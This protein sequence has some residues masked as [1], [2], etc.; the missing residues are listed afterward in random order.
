MSEKD[1]VQITQEYYDSEEA[2]NFYYHIWGGEDIHIGIYA[3]FE[4]PVKTAS[5]NT[6]AAMV[7]VLPGIN[8][9]TKI[10][11]IGSG[12]GGAA[13]YLASEYGC[14]VDCL[15]LSATENK[16]NEERNQKV[17]LDHLVSVTTGNFEDLPFEEGM[18]DIVWSQD[19]IL[20]SDKKA[21]VFEEVNR[22]LKPGGLFILT[23]P[24]QSDNCPDGVL[25]PILD[26]IHLK[27]MGSVKLYRQIASR[28]GMTEVVVNEMPEQ[29]VNHYS[30]VLQE[31][32]NNYDDIIRKSSETYIQRMMNGLKH[33]I[34]GGKKGYLNWG[35]LVFKK[36]T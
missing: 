12:Y 3:P 30:R 16:R 11:D 18:Y 31:V 9:D 29:L 4:T 25:D 15:N 26:R 32:E 19:A 14:K 6:V 23:D 27:E 13:R 20:H 34:A 22:V 24:M 36:L 8:E 35:I 7:E 33:W 1:L 17:G 28:L 10:L 2:D 21:R 5:R